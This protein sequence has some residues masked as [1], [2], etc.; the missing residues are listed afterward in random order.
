M[1]NSLLSPVPAR[2]KGADLPAGGGR[3][4]EA[5]SGEG[6][7]GPRQLLHGGPDEVMAA[8]EQAASPRY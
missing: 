5:P 4:L 6:C 1:V 7:L 8:G 2:P 3:L